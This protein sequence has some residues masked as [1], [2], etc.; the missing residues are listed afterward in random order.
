MKMSD[1][2]PFRPYGVYQSFYPYYLPRFYADFYPRDFE[3]YYYEPT[4]AAATIDIKEV[5]TRAPKHSLLF[6]LVLIL[7]VLLAYKLLA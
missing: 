5:S 4:A 1:L 6:W 3:K 2:Y 7:V